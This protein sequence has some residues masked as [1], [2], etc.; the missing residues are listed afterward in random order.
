MLPADLVQN[1]ALCLLVARRVDE[2]PV[3]D[4]RI[5]VVRGAAVDLRR[6]VATSCHRT[7]IFKISYWRWMQ[8]RKGIDRGF[9]YSY[10]QAH[11]RT[12]A[13]VF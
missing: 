3:T 11:T 5:P 8:S 4:G 10:R 2:G 12:M 1:E 13:T 9:K 6:S 7:T